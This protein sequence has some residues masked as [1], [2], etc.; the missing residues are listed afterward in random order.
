[1]GPS[2]CGKTTLIRIIAG[3]SH[4]IGEVLVENRPVT[5]PA[6]SLYGVPEF[7]LLPTTI[8]ANV[9]FGLEIASGKAGRR[10]APL[11]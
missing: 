2:G 7:G 10:G 4:A 3:Y 1:L 5:A 6:G 8:L 9:E 11:S